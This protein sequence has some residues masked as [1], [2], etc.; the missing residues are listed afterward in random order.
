MEKYMI[1]F[2]LEDVLHAMN[3]WSDNL[4][5]TY[6]DLR[7]IK[8]EPSKHHV[9]MIFF[10]AKPMDEDP[11]AE[12]VGAC[13]E[14]FTNPMSLVFRPPS[15]RPLRQ[16]G[17]ML[18]SEVELCRETRRLI[19]EIKQALYAANL[20]IEI[21]ERNADD[22]FFHVTCFNSKIARHH[23]L[24]VDWKEAARLVDNAG[25][26]LW[27]KLTR[28]HFCKLGGAPEEDGF[29][30][31]IWIFDVKEDDEQVVGHNCPIIL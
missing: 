3:K 28:L 30:E 26:F 23:R 31:S 24:S 21:E 16:N 15:H 9:T 12:I 6:P 14:T 18:A 8:C 13:M 1:C 20:D 17:N 25:P 2:R 22:E 5:R 11:I 7:Y 27:E 10:K 29:Y 4:V 19:G